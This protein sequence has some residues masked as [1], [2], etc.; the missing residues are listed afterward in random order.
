[1]LLYLLIVFLFFH[2]TNAHA[3]IMDFT[4]NTI[5]GDHECNDYAKLVMRSCFFLT[6]ANNKKLSL[7]SS[8]DKQRQRKTKSQ[9]REQQEGDELCVVSFQRK[10]SNKRGNKV[11]GSGLFTFSEH[12][13]SVVVYKEHQQKISNKS[14]D[15]DDDDET[16]STVD[17]YE[18]EFPV[19]TSSTRRNRP[20]SKLQRRV[21]FEDE[22]VTAVYT[23][24][25][26]T[27]ADKY[28]LHYDEYDYMDFKLEYRDD[29]LLEQQRK[30]EQS[31]NSGG[32]LKQRVTNYKR[33]PRKV[34]FKR[35]VV[36]SV[37][38]VMDRNQRNKILT[39]LFYTEEEMR[40]FLDEFVASLQKQSEQKA[41]PSS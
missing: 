32:K 30:R 8:F 37:H 27:K 13:D 16:A 18:D 5:I 40:T 39:D 12:R 1:M 25:R 33:S 36:D 34:S 6:R 21:Q 31:N 15:E 2:H 38:P 3:I 24:P 4:L 23:R 35:E 17:M 9:Q 20:Q 19:S 11:L 29:L 28:Y 7:G 22:L 41:I 26:T 10:I 14:C